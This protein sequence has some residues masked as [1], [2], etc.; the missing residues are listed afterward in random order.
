MWT[1]K[2]S[3]I[4]WFTG[5]IILSFQSSFAHQKIT[6]KRIL[7]INSYH[8]GFPTTHP[9]I[10]GFRSILHPDSVDLNIEFMDSKRLNDSIS[11]RNFYRSLSYKLKNRKNYDLIITSDDNA[12]NFVLKYKDDLFHNIPLVFCGINN[13]A[14]KDSLH[15]SEN[16]SG[17]FETVSMKATIGLA[18][19]LQK[20]KNTIYAITDKTTSGQ[21]DD[22]SFSET[23]KIFSHKSFKTLSLENLSFYELADSLAK[24]DQQAV[25]LLLSAYTDKTDAH[26]NFQESLSLIR[27]HTTLPIYHLWL[28]GLGQ[29]IIGGYMTDHLD[30]GKSAALIAK[31]ILNGTQKGQQVFQKNTNKLFLDKKEI[32]RLNIETK[33]CPVDVIWINDTNTQK[34]IDPLWITWGIIIFLVIFIALAIS[35]Y[36]II[37]R[38]KAEKA[39]KKNAAF[40]QMLFNENPLMISLFDNKNLHHTA[41]NKQM[42]KNLG[43]STEELINNNQLIFLASETDKQVMREWMANSSKNANSSQA[44]ELN[45]K[46]KDGSVFTT[47]AIY[48]IINFE[49][50]TLNVAVYVDIS[51]YKSTLLKLKNAEIKAIQSDQL[52]SAFL[53]NMSHEIRTPMNSILGFTDLLPEAEDI[54]ER[55][56]YIST[57]KRNGIY[58]LDLLNDIIDLSKIESGN[59]DLE[60]K[61][62]NLNILLEEIANVFRKN[63]KIIRNGIDIRLST[64]F[65]DTDCTI[66]GDKSRIRQSIINLMANATKFTEH[67]FISLRYEVIGKTLQFYIEDSGIGIN[68]KSL[69]IIFERFRQDD[70]N[71]LAIKSGSGLGL[72][73][74]RALIQL[75]GGNVAVAST[76][77][78]G[79]CFTISI[80]LRK[81]VHSSLTGS[82]EGHYESIDWSNRKVLVAEDNPDNFLLIEEYLK[83]TKIK[84]KHALNGQEAVAYAQTNTDI[85]LILMDIRMPVMDGFEASELIF[86]LAPNI[87][88]LIQT[89]HAYPSEISKCMQLPNY[90]DH[91]V[92]PLKKSEL[93]FKITTVLAQKKA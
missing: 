76:E 35:I 22:E 8:P 61:A 7:Y 17:V 87:P 23:A 58:M 29:G 3:I 77:G 82:Y 79:S 66:I 75:M 62:F 80:P 59:L 37:R 40:Y 33:N 85:D 64:A 93:I 42:Q 16:I 39:S 28:H 6:K 67:G 5:I 68:P 41:I 20:E 70:R 13:Q 90:K 15:N 4:F 31:N 24:L 86:Q 74:V 36:N 1:L 69:E 52:K 47:E 63:P 88:I 78:K 45:F 11:Q 27:N 14:I 21:I 84:I 19:D 54:T 30:Q 57:I 60:S 65:K 48:K 25:I 71:P 2:R 92:K 50:H 83:H 43:Y 73:I 46:R 38:R 34:T 49:G 10:N 32:K 81:A 18:F 56:R 26:L 72:S 89:A 55:D 51:E 44:I 9:L 91:L 12:L 53:A